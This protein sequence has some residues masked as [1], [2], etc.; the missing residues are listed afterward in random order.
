MKKLMILL[1][2]LGNAAF[3]Q[4]QLLNVMYVSP[5]QYGATFDGVTDDIAALE[6]T[7]NYCKNLAGYKMVVIQM[8][9]GVCRITR[10]WVLGTRFVEEA[11]C[12]TGLITATNNLAS[13][14]NQSNYNSSQLVNVISIEG[15]GAT[16]LYLDFDAANSAS[17]K[18]GIYYAI[19]GGAQATG[20]IELYT[21]HISGLGIY[22]KGYFTNG[23]PATRATTYSE[24]NNQA[25]IVGLFNTH[26][27]IYNCTF[28]GLREGL[29]LNNSS[30]ASLKK[31]DF[32][33][34]RRGIYTIQSNA[35][36][37]E[38]VTISNTWR[39]FEI[40]SS[41]MTVNN[42]VSNY[43]L[44]ALYVA[45][46]NNIFNSCFLQQNSANDTDAQLVI[47]DNAADTGYVAGFAGL[48]DAVVFNA[49]SI[50]ANRAPAWGG[51][52]GIALQMKESARRVAINGG[53]LQ[54]SVKY[55]AS[56][57][58]EL[59]LRAVLGTF[60]AGCYRVDADAAY[61]SVTIRGLNTTAV[62]RRLCIDPNGKV[63][64]IP[65]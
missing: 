54:S 55:L 40:R 49:L 5:K 47:G 7:Y 32:K 51:G 45:A 41:Q 39:G 65:Q 62:N 10:P 9:P 26:L 2:F 4:N 21:A 22:G 3:A 20:S 19:Q 37:V 35:S 50:V 11:D 17:L 58:N 33:N 34:C 59:L 30:F 61:K 44:N 13:T 42:Y 63:I 57:D 24:T 8:P 23:L 25:G 60:P 46:G 53:S 15:S 1:M 64:S 12:F 48:C 27:S 28:S 18:A 31:S 16:A 38:N 14:V 6:A 29:I 56:T 52:A 36:V 43:C